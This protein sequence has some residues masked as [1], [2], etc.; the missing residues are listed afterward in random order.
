M[1]NLAEEIAL[2]AY[3]DSGALRLGRPVFEYGLAGGVLLDL[4]LAGRIDVVDNRVTV[5]D[6]TPTD[7]PV[8]DHALAAIAA[9]KDRKPKDWVTRLSKGLPDRVLSSLVDAGVLRREQ[10]KVLLLFPRTRYP[11]PDGGEPAEET[12]ARQRLARAITSE[13]PVDP[14]TAALA[15]LVA[16]LRFERKVFK[17]LP[18]AQ[19]KARLKTI[20]EGDWAGKAVRRAVDEIH[21]VLTATVVIPAI[22]TTS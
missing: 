8:L 20:T 13:D 12:E 18:H 6:P 19:V 15:S 17:D 1:G 10:D 3:D 16:A 22:T 4:A 11:A 7:H 2:L 21:A 5:L 9:D 14:R